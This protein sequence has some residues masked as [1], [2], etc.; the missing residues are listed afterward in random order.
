MPDTYLLTATAMPIWQA[1]L[2]V[3]GVMAVLI[4]CFAIMYFA[5]TWPHEDER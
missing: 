4:G 5:I 1:L 3:A 2:I